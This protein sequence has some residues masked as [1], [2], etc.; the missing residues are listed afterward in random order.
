MDT[1]LTLFLVLVFFGVM[2]LAYT[3]W[4]V[5]LML[6]HQGRGYTIE[7]FETRDAARSL[8]LAGLVANVLILASG[9]FVDTPLFAL[10]GSLIAMPLTALVFGFVIDAGKRYPVREVCCPECEYD[11]RGLADGA[12]CC[13]ECGTRFGRPA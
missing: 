1:V 13:P 9:F 3:M 5:G 8:T 7:H 4:L 6:L 2:L 11:L 12:E 10:V